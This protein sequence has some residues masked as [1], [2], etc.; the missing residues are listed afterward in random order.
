MTAAISGVCN[1]NIGHYVVAPRVDLGFR[2]SGTRTL[3][4][5]SGC[6]ERF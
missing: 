3:D 4:S 1:H 5:G 2:S 6:K